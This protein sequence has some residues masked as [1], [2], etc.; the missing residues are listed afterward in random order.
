MR[1]FA[2]GEFISPE[3]LKGTG[4]PADESPLGNI[5]TNEELMIAMDTAAL[6]RK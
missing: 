2:Q 1:Q 4:P 3:H 5:P 6:T